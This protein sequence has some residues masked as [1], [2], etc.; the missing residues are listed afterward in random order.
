[1]GKTAQMPRSPGLQIYTSYVNRGIPG[2]PRP[3][4]KQRDAPDLCPRVKGSLLIASSKFSEIVAGC[5]DHSLRGCAGDT[6]VIGP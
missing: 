4:R 1:M 3:I 5:R 6:S 2:N